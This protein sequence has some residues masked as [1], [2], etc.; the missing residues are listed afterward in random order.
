M[1][2]K[3]RQT[4]NIS[5]ILEKS[6]DT[7]GNPRRSGARAWG[8]GYIKLSPVLFKTISISSVDGIITTKRKE[9]LMKKASLEKVLFFVILTSPGLYQ[10]FSAEE[11][12]C[13]QPNELGVSADIPRITIDEPLQGFEG[14]FTEELGRSAY[15]RFGLWRHF[16]ILE[17]NRDLPD[18]ASGEIRAVVRDALMSSLEQYFVLDPDTNLLF[19][20]KTLGMF[21]RDN[22]LSVRSIDFGIRRIIEGNPYLFVGHKF[23]IDEEEIL[24]MQIRVCLRDWKYPIPEFIVTVP[25]STWTLRA[26]AR[27]EVDRS[28]N[29]RVLNIEDSY[30]HNGSLEGEL[31]YFLGLQGSVFGGHLF[32]GTGYPEPLTVLF[33]RSF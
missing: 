12:E 21:V 27:Y 32:I 9:V 16:D 26:G 7:K 24:D 10:I 22:D 2:R 4:T 28:P 3:E 30:F 20:Y 11:G 19:V 18:F 17:Y 8:G 5:I 29:V 23:V 25:M 13:R 33:G 6:H 31:S 15:E 14:I 1:A